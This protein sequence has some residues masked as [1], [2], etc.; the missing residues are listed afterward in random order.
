MI[1]ACGHDHDDV[2]FQSL[3]FGCRVR[4]WRENG[5]PG[6]TY[7]TGKYLFHETT[8]KQWADREVAIAKSQGREIVP[9]DSNGD[10]Y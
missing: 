1:S 5:A 10:R 3:P 4:Y 9:C 8:R 6:V 7:Q 2:T